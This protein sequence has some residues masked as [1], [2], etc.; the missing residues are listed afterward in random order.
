MWQV[1]R[2]KPPMND[3]L[4]KYE[5][6]RD[7]CRHALAVGDVIK[8]GRVNFRVST[9]KCE[10]RTKEELQGGYHLLEKKNLKVLS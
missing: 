8:F 4:K 2:C 10:G 1:L 9:L 3:V 7:M 6:S 5:T